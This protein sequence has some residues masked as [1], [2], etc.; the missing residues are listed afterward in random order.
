MTAKKRGTDSKRAKNH[1]QKLVEPNNYLETQKE[2]KKWYNIHEMGKQA[3]RPRLVPREQK[4]AG[5]TRK[6]SLRK[7]K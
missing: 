5:G 6:H 4:K 2:H 7:E 3:G 1:D